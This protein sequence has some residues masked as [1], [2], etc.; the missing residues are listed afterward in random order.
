MA[1]IQQSLNQL[2]GAGAGA[3]ITSS[4]FIKQS[5]SYQARQADKGASAVEQTI[6]RGAYEN[7]ADPIAE[8]ERLQQ[9]VHD[10]REQAYTLKPTHAR[11]EA[12]YKATG[13]LADTQ[14]NRRQ[15]KETAESN[16]MERLITAIDSRRNQNAG[17]EER[18]VSL[19]EAMNT[20][21]DSDLT[22][23]KFRA[24]TNDEF[25]RLMKKGVDLD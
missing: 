13:A 10:L 5:P 7:A 3:A 4:Y 14:M 11:G 6:E 24:F 1:S 25:H 18:K 8:Q 9:K 22:R 2:I 16:L 21:M 23:S 17:L 15:S 20:I 19:R 12:L